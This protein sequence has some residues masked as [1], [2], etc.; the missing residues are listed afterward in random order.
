[1]NQAIIDAK[2][3]LVSEIA[4]KMKNAESAVVVEYRGLTVAE[5]Q[6]CAVTCV[7]RMLNS[8]CTRMRWHSVL[9]KALALTD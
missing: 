5:R 3:A 9:L 8:R 4:D 7:P 6:S 2:K 1:M